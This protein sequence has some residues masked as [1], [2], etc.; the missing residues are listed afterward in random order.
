MPT[1]P[2]TCLKIGVADADECDVE[3][4]PVAEQT[5]AGRSGAPSLPP[6]VTAPI[7]PNDV[8]NGVEVEPELLH[9]PVDR[10]PDG[11]DHEQI[12]LLPTFIA[13]VLSTAGWFGTVIATALLL[14]ALM[15]YFRDDLTNGYTVDLQD[16]K[17]FAGALV[18]SGL[19]VYVGWTWWSIS[20]AFN[21]KRLAPLATSP[22]LPTTLY[23]G[24]P[25]IVLIGVDQGSTTGGFIVI[26]G[27]LW[28]GIGHLIVVSSLRSTASRIRASTDEFSKVFWL[29]LAWVVY[30]LFVNTMMPSVDDSWKHPALLLLL[31]AFGALFPLALAAATWN[32]TGTFDAA[33]KR[34]NKRGT[35]L[36]LPS[37]DKITAAIR[38]RAMEGR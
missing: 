26:G 12:F 22:W 2:V 3:N 30:R 19:L 4:D 8:W 14:S 9:H 20:A 11:P 13:R 25:L 38:Q 6:R 15:P 32:A 21:A 28:I 36:E 7:D 23:F 35:A 17:W 27:C 37:A 24:G 1:V 31:G 10:Y 16:A 34:L 29:P 33:C 18:A 5:P